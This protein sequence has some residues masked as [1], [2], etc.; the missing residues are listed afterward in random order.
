VA[1][2]FFDPGDP[3]NFAQ[4]M[5]PGIAVLQQTGLGDTLIPLDTSVDLAA[6]LKLEELGSASGSEPLHAFT[7]ADPARYLPASQVAG[8]NGHNVMWDFA[9]VREQA[10]EFLGSDGR[11]LLA[12]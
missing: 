3:I 1:Q 5:K 7:R 10:L 9:P 2:P 11:V 6:A 12:P 8:Y 4:V